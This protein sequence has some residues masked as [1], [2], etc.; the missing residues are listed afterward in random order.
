M[1]WE[2]KILQNTNF[3][4]EI[5]MDRYFKMQFSFKN[6]TNMLKFP[7]NYTYALFNE[8]Q[9]FSNFILFKNSTISYQVNKKLEN[10]IKYCLLKYMENGVEITKCAKKYVEINKCAKKYVEKF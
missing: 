1:M 3:F 5:S 6:M 9:S 4:T 8:Q 7:V 2:E 10:F